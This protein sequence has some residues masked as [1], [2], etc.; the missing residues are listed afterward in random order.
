MSVKSQRS[1]QVQRTTSQPRARTASSR[2]FSS[3]TASP[4]SW[5]GRSRRPYLTFPSNSPTVRC[6]G[7]PKSEY[8]DAARKADGELQDGAGKAGTSDGDPAA[9]L[10]HAFGSPVRKG[11]YVTCG[12]HARPP[13]RASH[14]G[15]E[16]GVQG[17]ESAAARP[18][19]RRPVVLSELSEVAVVPYSVR[20][21]GLSPTAARK[22]A[23]ATV[24]A[25]SNRARRATPTTVRATDVTTCPWTMTTSSACRGTVWTCSRASSR[26]P[27]GRSNVTC[28]RSS[29]SPHV[30]RPCITPLQWLLRHL[31]R[32]RQ[33]LP[34]WSRDGA[35]RR[36]RVPARSTRRRAPGT[37][38]P[39]P[40]GGHVARFHSRACRSPSPR[41]GSRRACGQRPRRAP[42]GQ[43]T[44]RAARGRLTHKTPGRHQGRDLGVGPATLVSA[45][46][47]LCASA[48]GGDRRAPAC[49]RRRR[50]QPTAAHASSIARAIETA[51][52]SSSREPSAPAQSPAAMACR[53][54]ARVT[55]IASAISPSAGRNGAPTSAR[56]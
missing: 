5:P 55:H 8:V 9:R 48:A 43:P 6:W 7:Q 38:T 33:A 13:L 10:S 54:S 22:A 15:V 27:D 52:G 21:A 51:P 28:A 19:S 2:S 53:S 23:S 29:G 36:R 14:R 26:P 25:A 32:A 35:R 37:R 4:G 46:R 45:V 50:G 40:A 44:R 11:Q 16:P 34:A 3:K 20:R 17:R 41:Q 24:T 47:F 12:R 31:C 49:G 30:G 42:C 56:A 18:A 39:A 1:V